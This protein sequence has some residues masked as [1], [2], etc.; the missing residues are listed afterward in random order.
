MTNEQ[1]I[2]QMT[3]DIKIMADRIKEQMKMFPFDQQIEYL[4]SIR[5]LMV[6]VLQEIT[7]VKNS[8]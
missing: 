3:D 6:E 8:N 7:H 5:Y 2:A 1:L 4:K